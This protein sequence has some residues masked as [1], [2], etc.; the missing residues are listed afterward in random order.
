LTKLIRFTQI[1]VKYGQIWL[2]L[3]KIKILHRQNIRSLTAVFVNGIN[4]LVKKL[5]CTE[6]V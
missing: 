6:A 5:L 2:D 4:S 3:G 1:W